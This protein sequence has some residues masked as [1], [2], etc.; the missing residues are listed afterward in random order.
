MPKYKT[1][2]GDEGYDSSYEDDKG[3]RFSPK[4]NLGQGFYAKARKFKSDTPFK[5]KVNAARKVVVLSPVN[6]E[7]WDEEEV[8]RKIRFFTRVYPDKYTNYFQDKKE[9]LFLI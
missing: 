6:N 5:E 1:S 8:S 9:L 7:A 3:E 2:D 4:K